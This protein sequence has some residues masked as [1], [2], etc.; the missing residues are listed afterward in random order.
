MIQQINGHFSNIEEMVSKIPDV[1]LTEAEQYEEIRR[2]KIEDAEATEELRKTVKRAEAFLE[3]LET[4]KGDIFD[5]RI[6]RR[7]P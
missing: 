6:K 2:L 7:Y 5:R 3:Q 1:E 4:I